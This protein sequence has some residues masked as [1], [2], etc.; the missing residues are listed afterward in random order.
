MTK[1][2]HQLCRGLVTSNSI[3]SGVLEE[4]C[5]WT[6]APLPLANCMGSFTEIL[7]GS[8]WYILN[9]VLSPIMQEG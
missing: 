1:F 6:R 7:V 8:E 9:L 3:D 4:G 2:P 5:T